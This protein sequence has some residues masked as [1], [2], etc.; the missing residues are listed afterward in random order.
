MIKITTIKIKTIN[1][2]HIK[3]H[4]SYNKQLWYIQMSSTLISVIVITKYLHYKYT[5]II[6]SNVMKVKV[7]CTPE[8]ST[9][10]GKSKYKTVCTILQ[11]QVR[12]TI[13]IVA[14]SHREANKVL[15]ILSALISNR[16]THEDCKYTNTK[17]ITITTF[18][19]YGFIRTPSNPLK[20]NALIKTTSCNII[21]INAH[22]E[23]FTLVNIF[24]PELSIKIN[25]KR[26]LTQLTKTQNTNIIECTFSFDDR[27]K[28]KTNEWNSRMTEWMK[29]ERKKE[30]K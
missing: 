5:N 16:Q 10:N 26:L 8:I 7:L 4:T 11:S 29:K 12:T 3:F 17:L 19:N 27:N 25:H 18:S 15:T 24:H 22:F 2:E 23:Q 20:T 6:H 13:N 14:L 30:R 1:L 9:A 28:G 21:I